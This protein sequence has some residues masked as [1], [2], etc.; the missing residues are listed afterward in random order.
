VRVT[1]VNPPYAYAPE[2]H[3]SGVPFDPETV[4]VSTFPVGLAILAGI[5]LQRGDVIIAVEMPFLTLAEAEMRII[6]SNPDVLAMS[7]WT[8]NQRILGSICARIRTA[9]PRCKIVWGGHHATL[10]AQQIIENYEVD[11]VIQGE[12]ERPFRA[13]LEELDGGPR[14]EV[15]GIVRRS[16]CGDVQSSG[17]RVRLQ[18]L[19]DLPLPAYDHF[20]IAQ[21]LGLEMKYGAKAF[22]KPARRI[23]MLASRGCPYQCT[24]CVDGKLFYQTVNRDV[25]RVVDE[26][27]YLYHQHDVRLF[28][29]SD[30]TFTLSQKRTAA[31]CR[32]IKRRNLDISWQAM[33]RVNVVSPELLG[34]MRESGC[35]SVSYGV[36]TGSPILLKRI[37]KQISVS[38]IIKA[39]RQTHEAG[40]TTA[41]L[42]MIGNPGETHET[43][44]DTIDLLYEARPTQ[45]DPSI[46]QVYP[47]SQT[48]R[49][50]K[51]SGF[52]DDDFWLHHD[53]APYY[54]GEHDFGQLRH[55]QRRVSYHH[56]RWPR[57]R[58]VWSALNPVNFL[59]RTSNGAQI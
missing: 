31:L 37:R 21:D 34:I 23:M 27:E 29:F 14:A 54:V 39:F 28:E 30:M 36:E 40:L 16:Q 57:D 24:F 22:A 19:D 33:S 48:Y 25:N 7:C 44:G 43:I 4:P 38:D 46:Y 41:M 26:I 20:V 51:A 45:I 56:Q 42:L 47:G 50:L 58:R 3:D 55:W 9:L 13:L 49:E 2:E 6:S 12:G 5:A 15:V 18:N 53:A 1:F 59:R 17:E 10:F 11:F 52:I 35:Y 8:G 32:E